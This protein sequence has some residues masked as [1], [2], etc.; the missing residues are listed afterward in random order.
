LG[1]GRQPARNTIALPD[2]RHLPRHLMAELSALAA[3]YATVEGVPVVARTAENAIGV[4][5]PRE[6]LLAAAR[7]LIAQTAILHS[8]AEVVLAA[9]AANRSA[10]DW[11]WL[12]WLPHT[13]SAHS[14]LHQRHLAATIEGA[15][16]LVSGLDDLLSQREAGQA[17][18]LPAVVVLV[19]DDAPV[20]RSR[21]VELAE[22][23]WQYGI[24]VLWLA[25][26]PTHLPAACRTY[27][28]VNA[29][30]P[31]GAAVF[32]HSGQLAAPLEAELLDAAT[33]HDIARRLAPLVD[34]GARLDDDS[35]L[36]A[37]CRC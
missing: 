11:E 16:A 28:V 22:R 17:R 14:P 7:A 33:A 10:R 12:K 26:D 25:A 8:P 1:T 27:L 15:L 4:A 35:D 9:F 29:G 3:T 24:H 30:T 34:V 18:P 13:T 31:T 20:E 37:R 2:G 19:E 6:T 5:G 21:L 36:P 32:V 23:G